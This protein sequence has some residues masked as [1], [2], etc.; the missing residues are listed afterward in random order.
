MLVLEHLRA[1][2]AE[3]LDA[4]LVLGPDPLRPTAVRWGVPI[5]CYS[6]AVT[7]RRR[8]GLPTFLRPYFW[9][10]HFERL[11]LARNY[12]YVINRLLSVGTPKAVRWLRDQIGD[13]AIRDE[14]VRSKARG[15]SFRQ[16]APWVQRTEYERWLSEDPNRTIWQPF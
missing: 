3:A 7:R 1:S 16:V 5:A 8:T 11:S 4:T 15:L 14:V 2:R 13:D 6:L 9:D 10:A 12:G